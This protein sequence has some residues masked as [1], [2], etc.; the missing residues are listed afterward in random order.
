MNVSE[1]WC[2]VL[3]LAGIQV[4]TKAALS[5]GSSA[6][7]ERENR[8]KSFWFEIHTGD[9]THQLPLQE[10]QTWFGDNKFNLLL[11]KSE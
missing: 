2:S 6:A 8:A 5:L 3:T 10:K 1:T 9:I 11:N 4:S 7:Q